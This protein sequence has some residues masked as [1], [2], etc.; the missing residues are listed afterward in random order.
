M[1]LPSQ[2][3]TRGKQLCS[4]S[5]WEFVVISR[6]APLSTNPGPALPVP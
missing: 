1:L 4:N 3:W 2:V 6:I 5:V